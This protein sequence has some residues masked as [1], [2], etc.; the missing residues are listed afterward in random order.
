[1]RFDFFHGI[2]MNLFYAM[3]FFFEAM[4][5]FG[6]SNIFS[7]NAGVIFVFHIYSCHSR[8]LIIF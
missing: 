4:L 8:I 6:Q 7:D 5:A 3:I 2:A 1:M